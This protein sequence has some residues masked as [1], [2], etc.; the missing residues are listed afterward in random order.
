MPAYFLDSSALVKRYVI[1]TGTAWVRGIFDPGQVNRLAIATV[2]GAEVAAVVRRRNGGT[3]PAPIAAQVISDFRRQFSSDFHLINVT[4]IL[5]M[6]AM[7]LTERHGLRGYD[8]VQLAAALA[9]RTLAQRTGLMA[10]FVSAD[11]GLNTAALA[12]GLV[13]VDPNSHP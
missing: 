12:E 5:S 1:E 9:F 10:T 4:R 11:V 13:V 6:S 7:E 3:L 8:S 2:T